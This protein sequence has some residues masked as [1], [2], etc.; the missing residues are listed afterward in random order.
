M[1]WFWR[2]RT[3]VFH[4]RIFQL[5]WNHSGTTENS[6]FS[7]SIVDQISIQNW[8]NLSK[9]N[10]N[11]NLKFLRNLFVDRPQKRRNLI[12]IYIM[13]I[14]RE[15]PVDNF[16]KLVT[17]ISRDS[18]MDDTTGRRCFTFNHFQLISPRNHHSQS[19][20]Q[21]VNSFKVE[22]QRGIDN[23]VLFSSKIYVSFN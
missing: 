10:E 7:R 18:S 15:A 21:C 23:S 12:I 13:N 5:R 11:F 19:T 8:P 20:P 6:Q 2:T 22:S 3:W 16:Q 1:N 4:S 17:P 14:F 9:S